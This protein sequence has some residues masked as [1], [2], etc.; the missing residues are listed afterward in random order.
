MVSL[1]HTNTEACIRNGNETTDSFIVGR[2]VR[3]GC[4]IAPT[5][6]IMLFS[7]LTEIAETGEG[8]VLCPSTNSHIPAQVPLHDHEITISHGEYADDLTLL[9]ENEESLQK[10][11]SKLNETFKPV[12]V[13]I[14]GEKTFILITSHKSDYQAVPEPNIML[15]DE[16]ISI[17]NEFNLLGSYITSDAKSDKEISNRINM[18]RAKLRELRPLLRQTLS[19]ECK[20][21][22]TSR[23]VVSTLV[24]G[25][26]TLSTVASHEDRLQTVINDSRRAILDLTRRDKVPNHVTEAAVSLPDVRSLVSNKRLILAVKVLQMDAD[27][28]P[29]LAL[30]CSIGKCMR[31]RALVSW[32]RRLQSDYDWLQPNLGNAQ[33]FED[34]LKTSLSKSIK[35]V[36]SEI[37][38]S[39]VVPRR[40][41]ESKPRLVKEREKRIICS[42]A[43]CEAWFA[44]LKEMNRH[45]KTFHSGT[46]KGGGEHSCPCCDA[47]YKS[48]I[49][50][51]AHLDK[52]HPRYNNMNNGERFNMMEGMLSGDK[53]TKASVIA[54]DLTVKCKDPSCKLTFRSVRGMNTHYG[55]SHRAGQKVGKRSRSDSKPAF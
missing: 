44:E 39:A 42:D 16:R 54:Q 52:N 8:A 3:Q 5:L 27:A 34:W 20:T 7:V 38:S 15:G 1:F 14:A 17:V 30:L 45:L 24:H 26:E 19:V 46:K 35:L 11:L 48:P 31:G 49:R 55:L 21:K 36:K 2:G 9:S 41:A 29:K 47:T 32:E 43:G 6:F 37:R 18:A 25:T 51:K 4:R 10:S 33:N 22:I 53:E 40:A 50:L 13:E 28:Y 23:V 12:G